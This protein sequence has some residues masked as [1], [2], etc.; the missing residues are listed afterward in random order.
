MMSQQINELAKALSVV[1][2]HIK[3]AAKDS[4]N[5][6][7]NSK[8]ADL[9]SVWEAC[10]AL[11]TTNGLSV[12]QTNVPSENGVTLVTTLMHTS[13]QWIEG[14]LFIRP[15]KDDPQ[16]FGSAMTYARRYALAAIIGVSPEDDDGN[17]ATGKT[18][19]NKPTD[20]EDF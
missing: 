19:S 13:G 10:R 3:G 7:F 14:S 1:Q 8:Y 18:V 12:A 11:L 17:A 4:T 6:F 15:S 16:G 2:A 5:P 9:S 20:N